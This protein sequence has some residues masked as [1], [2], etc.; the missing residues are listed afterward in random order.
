MRA[1]LDGEPR[2]SRRRSRADSSARAGERVVVG[3]RDAHRVLGQVAVV[4]VGEQ[5]TRNAN[6]SWSP[7]R[8]CSSRPGWRRRS[9]CRSCRGSCRR[10][11]C[12]ASR[13]ASS[14]SPRR[15]PASRRTAAF[16]RMLLEQRHDLRRR[17]CGRSETGPSRRRIAGASAKCVGDHRGD[18]RG[19]GGGG[20]AGA[21]AGA[22]VL[23]QRLGEEVVRGR[24]GQPASASPSA[25]RGSCASSC[26]P[27]GV[28]AREDR[29]RRGT[30]DAVSAQSCGERAGWRTAPAGAAASPRPGSGSR[31]RRP[32]RSSS[33]SSSTFGAKPVAGVPRSASKYDPSPTID[34]VD[35]RMP[36]ARRRAASCC[37]VAP[38]PYAVVEGVE[39]GGSER[40]VAAAAQV[41]GAVPDARGARASRRRARS[42][43]ASRRARTRAARRWSC[44]ASPPTPAVVPTSGDDGEQGLPGVRVDDQRAV[45]AP[46][47][48]ERRARQACA[49]ERSA[50]R[51]RRRGRRR[52]AGSRV[53]RPRQ[54]QAA[55]TRPQARSGRTHDPATARARTGGS[56]VRHVGTGFTSGRGMLGAAGRL[57]HKQGRQAAAP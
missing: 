6:A 51:L 29:R 55:R 57:R 7:L 18:D 14:R 5:F 4:G 13:P 15:P 9:A 11:A 52:L 50:G 17:S 21:E 30:L 8:S 25:A 37:T 34:A 31:R 16:R 23:E 46:A 45:D 12:R 10:P 24:V 32:G 19:A 33:P 47:R 40:R 20:P 26:A 22:E 36:A 38:V 27:A 3:E 42:S 54:T 28:V 48:A 43:R 35:A 56:T 49:G 1:L 53:A 39:R 44:R 2:S 41:E